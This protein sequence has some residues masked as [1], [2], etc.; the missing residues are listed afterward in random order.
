MIFA[1]REN[2]FNELRGNPDSW[3]SCDGRLH[4]KSES[5]AFSQTDDV[6]CRHSSEF[7]MQFPFL[8]KVHWGDHPLK[9]H[10]FQNKNGKIYSKVR[11]QWYA[12]YLQFQ[13]VLRTRFFCKLT[14]SSSHEQNDMWPT[15]QEISIKYLFPLFDDQDVSTF[16]EDTFIRQRQ[17]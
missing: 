3:K 13:G 5:E 9:A 6:S 17:R 12:T 1:F 8:Q 10:R 2:Q 15:L 4:D 14:T 11:R 16:M 7:L